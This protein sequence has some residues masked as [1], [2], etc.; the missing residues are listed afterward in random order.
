M[1]LAV[2][3]LGKVEQGA[4]RA[5]K[6]RHP[7]SRWLFGRQALAREHPDQVVKAVL[8]V[9]ARAV[10]CGLDQLGI[11]QVVEQVL[12][13]GER[14]VQERGAHPA[15]KERQVQ[16]GKPAE[17]LPGLLAGALV[18]ERNAR[19][20]AH[21][22]VPELVQAARLVGQALNELLDAPVRSRGQPRAGDAQR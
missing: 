13:L 14:Q 8:A 2:G 15:G 19:P 22:A 5:F 1:L 20:D 6:R 9:H 16:Q 17:Q 4:E 11:D 12:G 10:A 21:V 18:G 7:L 3:L